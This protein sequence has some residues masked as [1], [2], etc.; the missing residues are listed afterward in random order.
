MIPIPKIDKYSNFESE[1]KKTFGSDSSPQTRNKLRALF[2]SGILTER[3]VTIIHLVRTCQMKLI[4][5]EE[6][7]LDRFPFDP[8]TNNPLDFIIPNTARQLAK[9]PEEVIRWLSKCLSVLAYEIEKELE[10]LDD[11]FTG[12]QKA[13]FDDVMDYGKYD[14]GD[15]YGALS[16]AGQNLKYPVS[17]LTSPAWIRYQYILEVNPSDYDVKKV[18]QLREQAR[19]EVRRCPHAIPEDAA[20]LLGLVPGPKAPRYDEDVKF[21]EQEQDDINE[22]LSYL[23]EQFESILSP[24]N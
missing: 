10:E 24:V 12:A 19:A 3:V 14:R 18:R 6:F 8:S 7:P 2:D 1:I 20:R 22:A 21:F 15:V 23:H 5:R 4:P 17:N 11:D 9:K 13:L 16:L